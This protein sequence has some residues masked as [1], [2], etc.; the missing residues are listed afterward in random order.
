MSLITPGLCLGLWYAYETDTFSLVFCQSLNELNEP[1]SPNTKNK[2]VLGSRIS[3]L[4]LDT[5]SSSE[6]LHCEGCDGY[7]L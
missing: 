3:V 7:V 5:V 4:T 2:N 6:L 1:I